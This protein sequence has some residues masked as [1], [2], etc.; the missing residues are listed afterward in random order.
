MSHRKLGE[1]LLSKWLQLGLHE[2]RNAAFF[3]QS[4]VV[5]DIRRSVT[6]RQQDQQYPL[7]P[8]PAATPSPTLE[9]DH[10][11]ER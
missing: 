9:V 5:D 3:E 8:T 7:A 10:S 6:D 2:A 4:N 11:L 1:D